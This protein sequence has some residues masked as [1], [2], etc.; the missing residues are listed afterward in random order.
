MQ[1]A[2][3][4]A[5]IGTALSSTSSEGSG[6]RHTTGMS[7]YCQKAGPWEPS[8]RWEEKC[9]QVEQACVGHQ[10]SERGL[11]WYSRRPRSGNCF[12]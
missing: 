2:G 9:P 5:A 4:T 10:Q 1:P 6:I 11:E 7:I 8:E 12:H 3:S